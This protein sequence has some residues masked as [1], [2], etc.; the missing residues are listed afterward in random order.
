V[1]A[2]TSTTPVVEAPKT[3][4]DRLKELDNLKA[5]GLITEK[6]YKEKRKEIIKGL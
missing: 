6:E 2:D 5:D 1:T 3:T 4:R